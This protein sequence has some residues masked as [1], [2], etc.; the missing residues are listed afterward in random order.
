MTAPDT[1]DDHRLAERLAAA[2]GRLLMSLRADALVEGKA[3]GKLGDSVSNAFLV[4]AL[5]DLR[6]DDAILSEEE[7]ADPARLGR[8]RIW[9]V[10][11]LDGTREYGEGRSDWAVHVA[12]C[13]DGRPVAGAVSVPALGETYSTRSQRAPAADGERRVLVSRTRPPQEASTVAAALDCELSGMGSAGA[14]TMAVLR[15]EAVAYVHSGGLHEWDSC[16]P[17]VVAAACGLHVSRLDGTVQ[18]YNQQDTNHGEL[19]IC[20][21]PLAGAVLEALA[22]GRG[23]T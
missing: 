14:K 15:G 18:A 4:G 19:L 10:D 20:A 23:P 13:V 17:A 1:L 8:S 5:Q 6:P 7:A 2:A 16:A 12:L 22:V 11:P 21:K 9:I 3:L